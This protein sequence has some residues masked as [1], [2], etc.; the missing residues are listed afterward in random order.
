MLKQNLTQL[1]NRDTIAN[2]IKQIVNTKQDKLR[3]KDG[4]T[5]STGRKFK[6]RSVRFMMSTK[7]L[8][9]GLARLDPH[10]IAPIVLGGVYTIVQVFQNDAEGSEAAMTTTLELAG[11]V[12]LWTRIERSQISKNSNPKL[13][14]YFQEL[15]ELIVKLYEGIIV[16]FGT[17]MAYFNKKR[18]GKWFKTL[19]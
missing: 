10:G 6:S 13:I 1:D 5:Q 16:L 18:F 8:A 9:M 15:S 17:M 2:D 7:D 14:K 11:I 3:A 19:S 4:L 12:A